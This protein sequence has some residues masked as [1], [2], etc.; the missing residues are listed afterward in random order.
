MYCSWLLGNPLRR[1]QLLPLVPASPALAQPERRK[2]EQR[3]DTTSSGVVAAAAGH[4]A[5]PVAASRRGTRRIFSPQEKQRETVER[6]PRQ[7]RGAARA[8]LAK[9]YGRPARPGHL[10]GAREHLRAPAQPR[11]LSAPPSWILP[12]EACEIDYSI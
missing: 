6:S 2:R 11:A 3:A 7:L 12:S 4:T 9:G 5:V 8:Q 10:Q 1:S